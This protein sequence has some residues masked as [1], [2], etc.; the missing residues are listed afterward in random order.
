MCTSA[1]TKGKVIWLERRRV[2]MA[3]CS[4][5]NN[6]V[7]VLVS[8]NF[9]VFLRRNLVVGDVIFHTSTVATTPRS[10]RGASKNPITIQQSGTQISALIQC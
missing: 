2:F 8:P 10:P 5:T 9:F 3:V 7:F 6:D 1:V 4:V